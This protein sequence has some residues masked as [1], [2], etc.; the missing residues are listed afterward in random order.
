MSPPDPSPPSWWFDLSSWLS[1]EAATDCIALLVAAS[2]LVTWLISHRAQIARE[3][4]D[5]GL[6]AHAAKEA[7]ILEGPDRSNVRLSELPGLTEKELPD[8]YWLRRVETRMVLDQPYWNYQD[9]SFYEIV[10]GTRVWVVRDR[11]LQRDSYQPSR[12]GDSP[13]PALMSSNGRHE[14]AA[15]VEH[16][17][18]FWG[19]WG[20]RL[21]LTQSTLELLWPQLAPLAGPDRRRWFGL[22]LSPRGRAFL[23]WYAAN[24]AERTREIFALTLLREIYAETGGD[25]EAVVRISPIVSRLGLDEPTAG[26]LLAELYGQGHVTDDSDSHQIGDCRITRTGID[27]VAGNCAVARQS[28]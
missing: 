1:A 3:L 2:A 18:M 7:W 19:R 13:H 28:G 5:Q 8:G 17:A 24:Y 9:K 22:G 4:L 12:R 16:I 10:G 20:R 25:L 15:W 21:Y 27:A 6:K 14:L 26:E 11:V 23:T